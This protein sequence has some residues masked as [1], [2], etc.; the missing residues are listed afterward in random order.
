MRRRHF[1]RQS[2]SAILLTTM[3]PASNLLGRYADL[4]SD[5]PC[6][7]IFS[8]HLQWLG[9]SEMALLAGKLGFTGID[10]TVRPGGHVEPEH[11][12]RDLPDAVKKIREAGLEV[13]MITTGITDPD[14]PATW[15]I[16]KCAG[17]L[18]IPLY[19]PGWYRYTEGEPVQ[20]Q[21]KK[22]AGQLQILQEVN[23]SAN[24]A[25]SYQNHS[26]SYIGSSGWDLLV[27]L[28]GLDPRWTGV[29]FDVRHAM[30]EGPESWPYVLEMLAPYINSLDIKDYTW[31]CSDK[32]A[33]QNVPLGTGLVP[34]EIY[35][36]KLEELGIQADFSVHFEYP[37]GGAEDGSRELSI[38]Q[39]EF[40][41]Q[42]GSDLQLLK[43]LL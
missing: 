3:A 8:K 43:S 21:L 26:G 4:R 37:L 29:Q 28:E 23:R 27:I 42:V 22:A 10:L 6:I 17:D 36:E 35:L 33:L 30:V 11:V 19:R 16:L 24:I 40:E 39:E 2:G 5:P 34:L 15:N 38:P 13:P 12:T 41:K 20:E 7:A 32:V 25:A 1:L 31:D 18:G 14:D 9:Y